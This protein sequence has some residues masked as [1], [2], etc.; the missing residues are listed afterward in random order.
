MAYKKILNAPVQGMSFVWNVSRPVGDHVTSPNVP[1]DVDLVKLLIA[2][3]IRIRQPGWFNPAL[4]QGFVI[5]GQMD[6]NTAYWIR[7]FNGDHVRRLK[8]NEAGIIDPALGGT[9]GHDTW[10]I[11]KLNWSLRQGN[12]TLWND[13]PNHPQVNAALRAELQ[14]TTP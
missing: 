2:E 10:T 1:T 11:V 7:Y 13:L 5:N 8:R 3:V 14:N 12:P 4:R 9:Y 6:M